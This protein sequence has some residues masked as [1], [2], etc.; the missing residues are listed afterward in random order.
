MFLNHAVLT[1]KITALHCRKESL[2][3]PFLDE[4]N[5]RVG[6][7]LGVAEMI[8]VDTYRKILPTVL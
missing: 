5:F 7:L 1:G 2:S 6:G 3:E 8:K 4:I